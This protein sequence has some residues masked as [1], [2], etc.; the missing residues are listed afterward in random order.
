M[1]RK[2]FDSLPKTAAG[3]IADGSPE[4]RVARR[5]TFSY[6]V[7]LAFIAVL[8]GCLHLLLEGV[9]A[10]Q[11]DAATV[12]NVAGRQ[13]MLSQRIALTA[14][15]LMLH[16][17]R[18][19]RPLLQEAIALFERQQR[20]LQQGDAELGITSRPSRA[21]LALYEAPQGVNAAVRGFLVD[22]RLIANSPGRDA[23][24][25]AALNRV[26]QLASGPLLNQLDGVV[27]HLEQEARDTIRQ[28]QN[29]QT[30]VLVVIVITLVAEAVFVFRPL[31]GRIRGY[32]HELYSLATV[33]AL[34][35]LTN[36]RRFM[37]Q[38]AQLHALG[39]RTGLPLTV[40][41][42]DIDH[43][44]RI[45]DSHGHAAGDCVLA[46]V[47]ALARACCRSTDVVG[48]IGGEEF[49]IL[50]PNTGLQGALML[51]EKVRAVIAAAQVT[52]PSLQPGRDAAPIP[53]T[54]SFGIAEAQ[55][56][57]TPETALRRADAA[58][59]I[60][61]DQGRNRVATG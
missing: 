42:F 26:T 30:A 35:R 49:G 22:A 44:K 45:N 2:G 23:E 9:I 24:V 20:A 40:V 31:V 51:A 58:L 25:D 16:D 52:A 54:A 36:R 32:M 34:T 27:R 1:P 57:E 7:G 46:E 28:L 41:V 12:I 39:G 37:E 33:D 3:G 11:N 55:P 14:N 13:R 50:L 21:V 47:A 43:F 60:A 4:D 56:Q 48:R 29:V 53:V 6:V 5:I 18:E 17:E 8:A 19:A 10:R 38:F 15:I 61:K 59:Y